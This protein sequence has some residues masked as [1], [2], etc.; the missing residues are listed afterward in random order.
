MAWGRVPYKKLIAPI[1]FNLR[2]VPRHEAKEHRL[3]GLQ[4]PPRA[5]PM[6]VGGPCSRGG[7]RRRLGGR[8]RMDISNV[9][10]LFRETSLDYG[11]QCGWEGRG[12]ACGAVTYTG[13][14]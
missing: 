14:R 11:V 12:K 2:N 9:V 6:G 4:L 10:H 3:K 1:S 5:V 8:T 13:G 7:R